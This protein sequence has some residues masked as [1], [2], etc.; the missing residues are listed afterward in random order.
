MKVPINIEINM[1]NS[2]TASPMMTKI[3]ETMVMATTASGIDS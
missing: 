2:K 3:L 1:D